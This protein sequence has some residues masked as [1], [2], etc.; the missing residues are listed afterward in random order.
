MADILRT[1]TGETQSGSD[2]SPPSSYPSGGYSLDTDLYRVSNALVE[3]D[4]NDLEA[5][6]TSYDSNTVIVEV[7]SEDTGSEV[8]GG[9]DL[10]TDEVG[11]TAVMN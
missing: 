5:R 10:S 4:N 9:F 7:F 3:I 8:S 6:A 1:A 2:D 11:Y